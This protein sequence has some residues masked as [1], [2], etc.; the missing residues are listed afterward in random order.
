MSTSTT[1][2]LLYCAVNGIANNTNGIGRQTKT[3]LA[4]L[5][6]HHHR[7]SAHAGAFTPYLAVPE[8]GPAT[9]GYNED[10][11]RYAHRI[12]EDLGG[13]VITLPYDTHRPFWHPDTWRHLSAEAAHAAGHLADRHKKVLAIGVDTPFA[14]LAHHTHPGVEV[15]LAL[16]STARI[17]ERPHP[18]PGRIAWEEEAIAAAGLH[19]RAWVADIGDFLTRHLQD[20]YRLDPGTLRAWPSGLDLTAADLAPPTRTEAERIVRAIGIP[21]GRPVV[22]A[23]G[24]TDHTKGLDLL[25]EELAPLRENVHL[26]MV[27][28][29][30]DDDRANLLD[31]YRQRSAELG[32]SATIIGRYDRTIPRALAAWPD[33]F[34]MAVPSRG[35]TLANIVFETA[36]WAQQGGAVVLAPNIDGFPEQ[37]TDGHNGLLYD[38][39][40][41]TLIQGLRR[42]LALTCSERARLRAAAH[43]TV[44]KQRNAAEHLATLLATFWLP[45]ATPVT[46]LHGHPATD[47]RTPRSQAPASTHHP[48]EAT[49]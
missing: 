36:L 24:R 22:A 45:R 39:A 49:P 46:T 5:A 4:T 29:P 10:D 8:P 23:I 34:A 18:D 20:Q 33:T 38:P 16:F 21:A 17:T 30:T 9:W 37:I 28:V 41:G 12:V 32:L 1:K 7:L 19:P 2:A 48:L 42:A 31:S 26:A 13:E 3:F 44:L 25:V 14:G 43:R 35:E 27:A 6:R 40:P 15:L 11:L 47:A